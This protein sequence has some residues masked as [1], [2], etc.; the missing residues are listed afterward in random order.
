MLHC[1][2]STRIQCI[3]DSLQCCDYMHRCLQIVSLLV[4]T[5]TV[6][7]LVKRFCIMFTHASPTQIS[8]LTR[9]LQWIIPMWQISRK[10]CN[11]EFFQGSKFRNDFHWVEKNF[12]RQLRWEF[13]I[14]R[15]P[16]CNLLW[17]FVICHSP[18]RICY[19]PFLF[20]TVLFIFVMK[21]EGAE[22]NV[23]GMRSNV[24]WH[25]QRLYLKDTGSTE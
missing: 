12:P 9:Q 18:F 3:C 17:S 4:H 8:L 7:T 1:I 20:V 14:V 19:G 24:I 13:V 16:F 6:L 22:W 15:R 2:S 25:R 23:W 10:R 5:T 21:I 11:I